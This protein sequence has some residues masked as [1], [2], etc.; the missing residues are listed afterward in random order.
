VRTEAQRWQRI[1]ALLAQALEQPQAQQAAWIANASG[2][3]M[4]L[5]AE[6]AS[7]LSASQ[8]DSSLL[9][10]GSFERAS[11]DVL[12]QAGAAGDDA[13][14][15]G[16]RLGAYRIIEPIARGGM[17]DVYRAERADTAYEQQV[18]IKLM[19]AGLGPAAA[20]RFQVERQILATLDHPNLAKLLDGGVTP[21]G[22]PYLVM[23]LVDGEPIDRHVA[24]RQLDTV[25]IMRLF[26]TLCEVVHYVHQR[27]VVHRDLKPGNVLVNADG[28]IK[29]LDFGIAKVLPQAQGDA[30]KTQQF[31]LTPEYSSPEQIRGAPVTP[32]SDVYSL[33]VLLY[34]LLTG[35]SPYGDQQG[36]IF[37]LGHAVSQMQPLPPSAVAGSRRRAL[38][39][40]VDAIVLKALSKEP[41]Q[42][43]ETAQA[44]SDDLFRCLEGL[45]ARA[46]RGSWWYLLSRYVIR[47]RVAVVSALAISGTLALAG[48]VALYAAAD[49]RAQKQRAQDHARIARDLATAMLFEVDEAIRV[50]PGSTAARKLLVE[51]SQTYL[52]ELAERSQHDPGLQFD[53][54]RSYRGLGDIQGRPES[55]S[56]GDSDGA[57]ASYAR[58]AALLEELVR[59]AGPRDRSRFELGIVYQ[60]QGSLLGTL[61]RLKEAEAVLVKATALAEA[62][63]QAQ[64]GD[65][66]SRLLL[67][68]VVVQHSQIQMFGA[69]IPA[70]LASSERA[71]KLLEGVLA[72]RPGDK[73][74]SVNLSSVHGTLA[75]YYLQRDKAVES[76]RLAAQ[77]LERA[78]AVL[79]P[80]SAASP[81]NTGLMRNLAVHLDNLGAA[82]RRIGS[83]VQAEASQ[84]RGLALATTLVERDAANARARLNAALAASGLGA[85]LMADRRWPE[86]EKLLEQAQAAFDGL[87]ETMKSEPFARYGSGVNL[88]HLGNLHAQ[89]MHGERDGSP[90]AHTHAVQCVRY[91]EQAHGVIDGM[92]R[93]FGLAPGHVQPQEVL[94]VLEAC[95]PKAAP[96]PG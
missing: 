32:A 90:G 43:Y 96:A 38:R 66:Q 49:A 42:R 1:K 84:R 6:L 20:V 60:R 27:G 85:T 83:V 33:G 76:A 30:A 45:P 35:K 82:Q 77:S 34:R 71:R 23:E 15:I 24:Q 65:V 73:D 4:G 68:T 69:N 51:K 39:G 8:Q 95:R 36:D 59:T 44:L 78:A 89:L 17:G 50:M 74:A 61:N 21:V 41:Q 37:R 19:V 53:L 48:G 3:D 25:A 18:A 93:E 29:L 70:F 11:T 79:E 5:H 26:R 14:W 7:L 54:A 91:L 10:T 47:H 13:H 52:R 87:P 28:T 81:D 88:Y 62:Y 72:D 9:S 75:E 63:A 67:A 86:A 40:D 57:L 64:P 46:G 56:L 12:Q 31:A 55:A 80:M 22:T 16:Q 2:T 94:Q 58:A 92:N